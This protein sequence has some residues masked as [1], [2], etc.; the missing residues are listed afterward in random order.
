VKRYAG[1]K[2]MRK[3]KND[4]FDILVQAGRPAAGV[5]G[6]GSDKVCTRVFDSQKSRM[7]VVGVL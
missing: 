2:K 4:R 6:K 1:G 7:G 5:C 3:R